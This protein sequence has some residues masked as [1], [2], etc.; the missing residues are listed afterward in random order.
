MQ[1]LNRNEMKNIMGGS[2]DC[3]C[4]SL[5]STYRR[6]CMAIYSGAQE[7]ACVRETNN[8]ESMCHRDCKFL[9]RT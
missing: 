5:Y 6:Q 8:L 1:T 2:E 7:M 9:S 3:G 4:Y